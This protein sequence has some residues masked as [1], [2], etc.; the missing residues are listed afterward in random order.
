MIKIKFL[1]KKGKCGE[2]GIWR[3]TCRCKGCGAG[4]SLERGRAARAGVV[5]EALVSA[6][7]GVLGARCPEHTQHRGRARG[8]REGRDAD[9]PGLLYTEL[10]VSDCSSLSRQPQLDSRPFQPGPCPQRM[11]PRKPSPASP[12]GRRPPVNCSPGGQALPSVADMIH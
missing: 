8:P 7:V 10:Q 6:G 11:G 9:Q 4:V 5:G 12:P 2:N 3:E 1:L